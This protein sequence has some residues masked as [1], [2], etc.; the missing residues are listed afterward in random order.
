MAWLSLFLAGIFEVAVNFT[1]LLAVGLII[2][3][4]VLLK[5]A[6]K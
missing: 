3:G 5:L 1:R 6:T 2:S 4:V